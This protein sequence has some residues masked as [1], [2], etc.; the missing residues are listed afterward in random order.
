MAFL[1]IIVCLKLVKTLYIRLNRSL[2]DARGGRGSGSLYKRCISGVRKS[3]DRYGR[4]YEKT[5]LFTAARGRMKKA[6][7]SG[8]NA[9]LLYA[10]CKYAAP[11]VLFVFVFII[12]FPRLEYPAAAAATTYFVVEYVVYAKTRRL[13]MK[14]NRYVYKIYKY[15]HNQINSG[16]KP[17][18]AIK[19]VYLVIEDRELR[20]ILIGLAA[21]Y[22]LTLNIDESLNEFQSHF[23]IPEAETLCVALKQGIQTGDNTELLARQE[24]FMFNRYFNYIQA[25]TDS[26]RFRGT[27]SVLV[28]A[29]ITVVMI[30]VPLLND[31]MD[32]VGKIFVS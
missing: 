19:T 22:E 30:A 25:E 18:D 26:C 24:Q 14:F 21:R 5:G 1:N 13:S 9:F 17:T 7:Y 8:E 10:L 6:G 3:V 16:V 28:F 31:V 15:L 32:A 29:S 11:L 27:V 20:D 12:N 23:D 2:T 4:K